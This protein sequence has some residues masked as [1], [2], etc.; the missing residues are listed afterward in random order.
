MVEIIVGYECS[1]HVAAIRLHQLDIA[2]V[3]GMAEHARCET[4]HLWSE[5]VFVALPMAHRLASKGSVV[6]EDLVGETFIV[7]EQASG[8][9]KHD[10]LIKR[11]S[12]LGRHP[13]VRRQNVG[14]D[15]LMSLVAIGRGLTLT[16]E[17]T[18]STSFHGL[19]YRPIEGETL[20][21]SAVWS[22][23]ND[24]PALRRLLSTARNRRS[25]EQPV[26]AATLLPSAELSRTPGPS[27]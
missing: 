13:E 25:I 1:T 11:L 4:T 12:D 15:N 21:F 6:W 23:R 26:R 18:T 5:Q 2:F 10:V 17:A 27:P 19:V 7:T 22:P 14:R 20:P 8:R 9:E 3:A 24:N 16:S